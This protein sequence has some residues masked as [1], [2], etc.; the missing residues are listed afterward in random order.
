MKSCQTRALRIIKNSLFIRLFVAVAFFLLAIAILDRTN[1]P[2]K[3]LKWRD[4]K[5][6]E[7]KP[8]AIESITLSYPSGLYTFTGNLE[9]SDPD[10]AKFYIHVDDCIKGIK[11]NQKNVDIPQV[12]NRSPICIGEGYIL[13][14]FSRFVK[15]GDNEIT[16]LVENNRGYVSLLTRSYN[17]SLYSGVIFL[18]FFFSFLIALLPFLETLNFSKLDQFIFYLA[19]ASLIAYCMSTS[20]DQRS[21]DVNG[22]IEYFLKILKDFRLYA[23]KECWECSQQPTY[24]LLVLSAFKLASPYLEN[25]FTVIQVFQLIQVLFGVGFFLIVR[26]VLR[27]A[28][29]KNQSLAY[30]LLATWLTGFF[31]FARIGN[32]A[33]WYLFGALCSLFTLKWWKQ[34]KDKDFFW[35]SVYG[36]C[37]LAIKVSALYLVASL[38]ILLLLRVLTNLKEIKDLSQKKTFIRKRFVFL[39]TLLLASSAIFYFKPLLTGDVFLK[40]NAPHQRLKISNNFSDYVL[41]SPNKFF[42]NSAAFTWDP[43]SGRH[44][45]LNFVS[46]SSL[47]G[48]F[49]ITNIFHKELG[50]LQDILFVFL[51]IFLMYLIYDNKF[52]KLNS[53]LFPLLIFALVAMLTL[54]SYRFRYPFSS[55]QDFRYIYPILLLW[56]AFSYSNKK[57]A[58]ALIFTMACVHVIFVW[59][60]VATNKY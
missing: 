28:G 53:S 20:W 7:S 23:S 4:Q 48:E 55:N 49:P 52:W 3:N 34:N 56:G 9:V 2:L 54:A 16:F 12:F 27:E 40:V 6:F 13:A 17:D 46:K 44:L 10:T 25:S 18:L 33:P 8:F 15:A 21:Y 38:M 1:T 36:L 22:H 24:Y 39:G 51:F 45:F 26:L 5:S 42:T 14:N 50:T 19:T 59:S 60:I 58:N 41:F 47:H 30:L 43:N 29:G 35:A 11:V 37:A 57:W 32:D 31:H